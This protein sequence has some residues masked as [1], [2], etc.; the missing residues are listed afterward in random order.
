[1]KAVEIASI[2]CGVIIFIT[3]IWAAVWID[4]INT[5]A[6]RKRDLPRIHASLRRLLSDFQDVCDKHNI[7]YW[8][9]GGTLLGAIRSGG[10]IPHDDDIDVS[11]TSDAMSALRQAVKDSKNLRVQMA[12]LAWGV[13]KFK[14]KA[15]NDVWIDLF[16]VT[17]VKKD[18]K[19]RVHYVKQDHR[20]TWP[21]FWHN[22]DELRPLKKVRFEDTHIMIP[23]SPIV[24]LERGYGANWRVPKEYSLHTRLAVNKKR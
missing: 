6:R 21:K 13:H 16:E 24:Y 17:T 19:T 9:D 2:V 20:T 11:L 4:R 5:L 1:M 8:A 22:E 18:G 14:N 23:K 12:P 10:I 15:E 7:E 3:V